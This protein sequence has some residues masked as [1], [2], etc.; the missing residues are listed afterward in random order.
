MT[1]ASAVGQ[2]EGSRGHCVY[3]GHRSW[4]QAGKLTPAGL[5]EPP[6]AVAKAAA[7]AD[8]EAPS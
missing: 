2:V 4:Q 7:I 5:K 8:A 3:D 6:R 1:F